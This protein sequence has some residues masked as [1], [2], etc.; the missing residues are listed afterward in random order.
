[1]IVF[2]TR[3]D[4][5]IIDAPISFSQE[6]IDGTKAYIK[7]HYDLEVDTISIDPKMIV[8]HAMDDENLSQAF[9]LFDQETIPSNWGQVTNAGTVNVSA[10]FLITRDGKVLRL[11]PE[12]QMARHVIGLNYHAIGIENITGPNNDKLTQKQLESNIRLVKY[13]KN[14]YKRIQYLIGHYEYTTFEDHPL[15]MEKNK[16]YRTKKSDPTVEFMDALH[17]N[18]HDFSIKRKP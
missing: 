16:N 9:E 7:E 6:R 2:V 10:H 17:H 1:M 15:W 4:L 18:L 3:P 5:S 13:L 11:M 8:I 12:T 14:K